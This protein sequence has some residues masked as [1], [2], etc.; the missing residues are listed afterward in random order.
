MSYKLIFIYEW[1][2]RLDPFGSFEDWLYKRFPNHKW[3]WNVVVG[4]HDWRRDSFPQFYAWVGRAVHER[5]MIEKFGFIP[6][7]GDKV[8]DCRGEVH[9]IAWVDPTDPDH[10]R[11]DDGMACSLWHC[12][13]LP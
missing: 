7:V 6:S 5:D 3:Y 4:F 11:M 1:V 2:R 10:V 13:D 9:T 12:C 8:E